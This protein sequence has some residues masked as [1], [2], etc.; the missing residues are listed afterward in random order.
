[1]P[2]I[3]NSEHGLTELVRKL[4]GCSFFCLTGYSGI[5]GG[6]L[7]HVQLSS[8]ACMAWS[9]STSDANL[10]LGDSQLKMSGSE[11]E[12]SDVVSAPVLHEPSVVSQ[13]TT[14]HRP[15]RNC[16]FVDLIVI[17]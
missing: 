7:M 16:G 2:K 3:I 12:S 5:V 9:D 15:I 17:G 1:M 4:K 13:V 10:S 6:M 11:A 14:I 8:P